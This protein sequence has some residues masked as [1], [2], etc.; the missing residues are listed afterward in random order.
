M[1]S[2]KSSDTSRL[3]SA[4]VSRILR[5][6]STGVLVTFVEGVE[7]VEGLQG[8]EELDGLD[9]VGTKLLVEVSGATIGGLGNDL[10]NND[11]SDDTALDAAISA[12]A[13]SFLQSPEDTRVFRVRDFAPELTAWG[14]AKLLFERLQPEPRLVVC[15]A[16]HVG[17]ALSRIASLLGYRTTLIDDRLEFLTPE[18]FSDADIELV[19]AVNWRDAVR[20]AVSNGKGISIAIVTRGHSEDEECLRASIDLKPDY[21]GL[22]GSK[23]RTNIVLERLRDEGTPDDSLSAVRAPVGLD[24]GAVTPE[25]VALAIMSEIVAVRRGGE[26]RSLSEWRRMK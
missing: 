1:Q 10:R 11:G 7:R 9:R 5:Q 20:S 25:E 13:R 2:N 26:G 4:E 19:H 15:G 21:V 24:I 18:Q 8:V 23:R 3:I 16:G 17:A 22:I 14:D 6:G 12:K